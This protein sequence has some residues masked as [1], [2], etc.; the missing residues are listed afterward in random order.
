MEGWGAFNGDKTGRS[1]IRNIGRGSFGEVG[2]EGSEA[3]Y[4]S[5]FAKEEVA[6]STS[7]SFLRL[8]NVPGLLL[9]RKKINKLVD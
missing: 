3:V 6:K 8:L 9:K 5:V 7:F 4:V 2:A 1:S